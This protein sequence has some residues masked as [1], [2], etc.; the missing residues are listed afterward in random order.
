MGRFPATSGFSPS[1]CQEVWTPAGEKLLA[2]AGLHLHTLLLGVVANLSLEQL[3]TLSAL[4]P[5]LHAGI[6][7]LRADLKRGPDGIPGRYRTMG[8]VASR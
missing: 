3:A 4:A 1:L 5:S 6:D 8:D 7:V 2:D